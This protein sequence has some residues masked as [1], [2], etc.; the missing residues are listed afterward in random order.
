[1]VKTINLFQKLGFVIHL[2]KRKFITAKIVEYLGF[3]I[4]SEKMKSYLSDQKKQKTYE[5]CCIIPTKPKLTISEFISFIATLTSSFPG[6]QFGPLHCRA[7]LKFK[8][9]I[10]CMKYHD[11]KRM[12]SKCLNQ[13]DILKLVSR[14][15]QML[16][17]KVGVPPWV[18][19]PQVGHDFQ[20]R[21]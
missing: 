5:K 8:N 4:D 7:M 2:H 6:N 17:L 1:M 12:Y 10:L 19:Y 21:S 15:T 13:Q 20:M 9:K 3:T 18:M 11:G 14:F 16:H